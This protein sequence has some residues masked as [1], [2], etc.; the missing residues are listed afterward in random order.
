MAME[1]S[2]REIAEAWRPQR[3]GKRSTK[4]IRD[5]IVEP[6][7]GGMRVVA[8]LTEDEAA[9]YRDGGDVVAPDEL[10]R[11]LLDAFQAVEAVVEGHVTTSALRS[12]AGAFPAMPKVER[13]PILIPKWIRSDVKDDPYIQARDHEKAT[14][15]LEP[16]VRDALER[17]ERHAFV[18]TDLLWVDGASL[19]DVPLLER[20]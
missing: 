13:P 20:R 12:S 7:W 8:A 17:G 19:A 14:A 1:T 15:R 4:D 2:P 16:S 3:P 11:A 9:L 10:L 18:A 5:A 6:E